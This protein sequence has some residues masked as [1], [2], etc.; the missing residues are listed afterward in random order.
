MTFWKLNTSNPGKL[1]EFQKL[2]A[3]WNISLEASHIDL[4]EIDSD[5]ISVITHKASQLEE[6]ILVEDTSLEVEGAAFG[7]QIR[8]LIN[9]LSEYVDHRAKWI[10]LLAYRKGNEVLIYE[11][12]VVGTIVKPKGNEGF[13]FDSV[14]LPDGATMTLA[15]SKPTQF[16]ARA[17]AVEALITNHIFAKRPLMKSWEGPWQHS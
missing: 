15:E 6:D 13:G 16:N 2:F 1:K 9:H 12:H 5:P 11:G 10:A 8:W 17:K 14:F 3:H 7:V 4:K